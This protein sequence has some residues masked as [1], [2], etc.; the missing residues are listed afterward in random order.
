MGRCAKHHSSLRLQNLL[1][2]S[3]SPM[4]FSQSLRNEHFLYVWTCLQTAPAAQMAFS[5]QIVHGCLRKKATFNTEHS[6]DGMQ[7]TDSPWVS[8]KK[9]QQD[10]FGYSGFLIF[11]YEFPDASKLAD[12]TVWLLSVPPETS[13]ERAPAVGLLGTVE[14]LKGRA[15]QGSCGIVRCP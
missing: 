11:P 13:E 12:S 10:C 6:K 5:P 1:K 8:R 9:K 15:L 7:S 4:C 2:C 14:P 3:F